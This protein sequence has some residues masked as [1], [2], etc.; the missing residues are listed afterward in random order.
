MEQQDL[1]SNIRADFPAL[2][3][4]ILK[5]DLIYFDTAA[6]AQK[7]LI[8]INELS[9]FYSNHY[10]NVSRGVH[11]LCVEATFKY[12]DAR[13]KIQKF[14]NAKSENEIIFT[15]NATESINLIAQTYCK[16]YLKPDDEIILSVMEHHSNLLPWF[17]LRDNYGIVL[18]F[19]NIDVDGNLDLE[20]FESLITKKTKL[21][22]VTHLSNVFG[23]ITDN[24]LVEISR[25]NNLHILLDGCQSISHIKVDVQELDCDFYVFSG[26]KIYG[27]SGIGVLYGKE[28]LLDE[29]PPFLGGGG[30]IN[31]VSLDGA[32]YASLPNKFEAGTPPLV[33]AY[34]LGVAIDY[35]QNIGMEKIELYEKMLTEYAD[36]KMSKL[37]FVNTYSKSNKKTSII[38]FN[39]DDIHAHEVASFLDVQG[40]AVRAGHHCCQPL[41][42]IL[43]VIATSRISF[44]VYNTKSEIDYFVDALVKCKNFFSV[45]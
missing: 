44:G 12:E 24:K 19:I 36:E 9:D 2:D 17:F 25:A 1:K 13:K 15:K 22:A 26:H 43:D 6:S 37:D 39:L 34:G 7:P 35:V 4:K 30:M 33:E 10:S 23:T 3:K 5:N 29:L 38:S 32:T 11:T 41:M 20:H 18:K 16:K 8:V 27:P 45:K 14:I 21:V 42:K 28:D 31:E 40:I